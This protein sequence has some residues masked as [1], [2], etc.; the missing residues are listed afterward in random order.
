MY[1]DTS[2]YFSKQIINLYSANLIAFAVTYNYEIYKIEL[3]RAY[4]QNGK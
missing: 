2:R 4:N 1:A 3:D